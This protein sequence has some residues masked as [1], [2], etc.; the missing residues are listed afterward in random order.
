[1]GIHWM[2]QFHVVNR[3]DRI[4]VCDPSEGICNCACMLKRLKHVHSA[5]LH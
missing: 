2:P 3:L 5:G 4:E 1:L